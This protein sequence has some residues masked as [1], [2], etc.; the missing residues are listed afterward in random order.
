M[1]SH[2]AEA[3]AQSCFFGKS[4]I[5][6]YDPTAYVEMARTLRVLTAAR[7]Y[8]IGIPIR[9]SST[10]LPGRQPSYRG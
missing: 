5:E 4:F 9:T 6:L 3:P 10:L 2:L 7:N 1:G 8:Q